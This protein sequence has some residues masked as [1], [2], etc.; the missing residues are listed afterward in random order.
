MAESRRILVADDD[1]DAAHA[2]AELLRLE[3]HSADAA[4]GGVHALRQ[5]DAGGYNLAFLDASL[6]GRNDVES[7]FALRAACAGMRSYLMTGY[8]IGQ[9][10][11]QMVKN[12]G[13]QLLHG[14]I[15][16]DRALEA[17]REAGADGIILLAARDADAGRNLHDLLAESGYAVAHLSEA[18]EMHAQREERRVHV[19][20]L[21]LGTRIIDALGAYAELQ[22]EGYAKPAIIIARSG[23]TPLATGIITKPYDPRLLVEQ[24]GR[25]AA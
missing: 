17:V 23:E 8:S 12:D 9:L 7:Y 1:A 13:V 4:V 16:Q 20:I 19:V 14:P 24:I 25:L 3:G 21:D 11:R 18:A 6:P 5:L 22:A 2:L 15:G 10:L